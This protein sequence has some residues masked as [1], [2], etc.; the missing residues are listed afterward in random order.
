MSYIGNSGSITINDGAVTTIK[1]ADDAVTFAKMQN[2]STSKVLGRTTSGT[3]DVEELALTNFALLA[4]D[5]SWSGS[6]RATPVTDN[7]GSFDMNAA[8]DFLCTP[9]GTV[10]LVFTNYVQGQRG[11]I[12]INNSTSDT[13]GITTSRLLGPSGLATTLSATGK[14]WLSYWCVDATGGA[15]IV[16]V[17]ATPALS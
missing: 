2:V 3:G 5:Q 13:V 12:Y 8:N 1:L 6:Q 17:T 14:Y 7:D 4:S 16:L 10:T 9:G 15:E 11:C